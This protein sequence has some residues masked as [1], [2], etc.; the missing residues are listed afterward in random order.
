MATKTKFACK[1]LNHLF[2][3]NNF[4]TVLVALIPKFYRNFF[5]SKIQDGAFIQH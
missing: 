2:S 5:W 3:K 4:M 1:T